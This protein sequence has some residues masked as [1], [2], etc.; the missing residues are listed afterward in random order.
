MQPKY[1]III[2]AIYLSSS[3]QPFITIKRQVI[4]IS[5]LGIILYILLSNDRFIELT[6]NLS[7]ILLVKQSIGHFVNNLCFISN[8]YVVETIIYSITA[9]LHVLKRLFDQTTFHYFYSF[10]YYS[11]IELQLN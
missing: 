11:F 8:W 3:G 2:Y 6:F 4:E 5:I 1:D 7:T 9:I 10:Y